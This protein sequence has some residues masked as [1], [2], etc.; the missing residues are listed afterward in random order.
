MLNKAGRRPH[1]TTRLSRG[2]SL[3][4]RPTFERCNEE[5]VVRIV[6]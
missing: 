4:P 2:A 6:I 3:A 5:H 1:V